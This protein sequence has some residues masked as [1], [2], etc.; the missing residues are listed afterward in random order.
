[1]VLDLILQKNKWRHSALKTL[2]LEIVQTN[3]K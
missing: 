1:M 2:K 3:S